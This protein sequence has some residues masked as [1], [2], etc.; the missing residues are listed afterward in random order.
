MI[1]QH[2]YNNVIKKNLLHCFLCII[3]FFPINSKSDNEYSNCLLEKTPLDSCE[4]YGSYMQ[5]DKELNLVYKNMVLSLD[6]NNLSFLRQKQRQWIKWRDSRCRVAQEKSGCT[7]TSCNAVAHD[8]CIIAL[9]DQRT[10]ELRQF[11]KNRKEIKNKNFDF[12]RH[13]KYLDDEF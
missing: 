5:S 11:I 12:S 6:K 9:T 2:T 7:N 10:S 1:C 13:N 3:L 4:S 8:E